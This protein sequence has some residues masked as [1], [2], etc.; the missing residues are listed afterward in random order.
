MTGGL[1]EPGAYSNGGLFKNLGLYGALFE[2]GG[3]I[4]TG[5]LNEDLGYMPNIYSIKG[6]TFNTHAEQKG[7][8]D[9]LLKFARKGES[10]LD[11]F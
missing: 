5:G 9:R 1:F 2:Y 4:G 11:E 10:P 6:T 3:L 8:F 7:Y